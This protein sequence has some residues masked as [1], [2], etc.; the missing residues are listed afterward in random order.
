MKYRIIILEQAKE[1]LNSLEPKM[2]AKA[3]RTIGL[4]GEFGPRLTLPHSRKMTGTDDL[5]ELRIQVATN[6]CRLFYFHQGNKVYVLLSGFV[7]KRQ[8]TDAE[9]IARALRTKQEYLEQN[10][11]KTHEK[12]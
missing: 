7:K 8:K 6:I 10:E 3:Y 12:K 11:E 9:E 5:R 2:L 1:F 4:L